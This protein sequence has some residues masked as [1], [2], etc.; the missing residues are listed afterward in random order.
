[1]PDDHEVNA[2]LAANAHLLEAMR[3]LV[4]LGDRLAARATCGPTLTPDEA[5]DA[6]AELDAARDAVERLD[7]LLT[8]RRLH[9][10]EM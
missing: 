4:T 7:T 5:Q 8:L 3:R 1:M 9:L 2:L 6:R 10:R